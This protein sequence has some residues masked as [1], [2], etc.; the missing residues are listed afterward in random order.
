MANA[1][2]KLD[3][4]IQVVTPENIAFDY[5]I[6]GPFHRFLAFVLDLL[7]FA[8]IFFCVSFLT[9]MLFIF[10]IRPLAD[11]M[12]AP[13]IADALGVSRRTVTN[14]W[15]H[16]LAW[17][18]KISYSLY[19]VHVPVGG[20]VVNLGKRLLPDTVVEE[21]ALSACALSASLFVAWHFHNLVEKPAHNLSRRMR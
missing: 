10:V 6:A 12:G 18:G 15:R 8:F 3:N 14:D 5:R 19:L 13:E 17:L 1:S 20:R 7:I 21:F 16:A 4:R 2:R 9:S 11:M